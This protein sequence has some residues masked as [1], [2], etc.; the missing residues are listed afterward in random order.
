MPGSGRPGIWLETDEFFRLESGTGLYSH[1]WALIGRDQELRDL[2][3]WLAS[4]RRNV[5]LVDGRGGI[6]KSR[7]LRTFAIKAA[8]HSYAVRFLDRSFSA[9]LADIELLPGT[10]RLLVVVDD[11]HESP[12][13][14]TTVAS[15]LRARPATKILLAT[16]P[17]GVDQLLSDIRFAGLHPTEVPHWLLG[18][19]SMAEA[20]DLAAAVL[21]SG[22]DSDVSRRLAAIGHDCPLIIV[23]GAGLVRQGVLD[24][25]HMSNDNMLRDEVMRKFAEVLATDAAVAEPSVRREVLQAVAALQ[26]FRLLQPEFRHV[27]E[28]LTGK[29][30]DQ[31]LVHLRQLENSGVLLRRGDAMRIVPDLLGDAIL[32][33][34]SVDIPSGA[35]TGYLDRVLQVADGD[36]LLNLVHNATRIDWNIRRPGF[37]PRSSLVDSLWETLVTRF[38]AADPQEQLILLRRLRPMAFYRQAPLLKIS[39]LAYDSAQQ[40]DI[41]PDISDWILAALPPILVKAATALDQLADSVDLLWDLAARKRH[42]RQR[43]QD[44][45]VEVLKELAGFDRTK[46]VAFNLGMVD[47]VRRWIPQRRQPRPAVSPREILQAVLA[48]Q[49]EERVFDGINVTLSRHLLNRDVVTPVRRAAADLILEGLTAP[50]RWEA[51]RAAEVLAKALE[52]PHAYAGHSIPDEQID[53][54][55]SDFLETLGLLRQIIT[56]TTVDPVVA[57]TLRKSL[58]WHARHARGATNPAAR[59]VLEALPGAIEYDFAV[60]L[61]DGWGH[62]VHEES[63]FQEA[64]RVRSQW[65][66]AFARVVETTWS[67]NELLENLVRGLHAEQEAAPSG[68]NANPEPFA[69]ALMRNR[70]SLARALV[71][72]VIGEPASP[73]KSLLPVAVREL[74]LSAADVGWDAVDALLGSGDPE[75]TRLTAASLHRF[76]GSQTMIDAREC[77]TLSCLLLHDDEVI[78][79]QALLAVRQISQ[80]DKALATELLLTVSFEHSPKLAEDVLSAFGEHG[81]LAYEELGDTDRERIL[82]EISGLAAINEYA[83]HAF[84]AGLSATYPDEIL[85]LLKRRSAAE[86]RSRGLSYHALPERWHKNLRVRDSP[87]FVELLWDVLIWISENLEGTGGLDPGAVFGAVAVAYDDVVLDVLDRAL[88]AGTT[89]YVNAVAEVLGHAHHTFVW[90]HP[91][92][93]ARA[94]HAANENGEDCRRAVSRALHS[95][96]RQDGF[97]GP[98]G[99]PAPQH[100]EQRDR[101]R[102]IAATLTEGTLEREFFNE[103]ATAAESEIRD[104][105]ERD[106]TYLESRDW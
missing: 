19:L 6:G 21:G 62:L 24:P 77:A 75:L 31:V 27:A 12:N 97:G 96:V 15:L 91:D 63:D 79:R 55:T 58:S 102:S 35:P 1:G 101:S 52:Y 30:F 44:D 43:E 36:A 46:P 70:P 29:A 32:T 7:L 17:Y 13:V 81:Y 59:A 26:P 80:H 86:T 98:I 104:E 20:A 22:H 64:H 82:T 40:T 2:V 99:E 38:E 89:Q 3:A 66:D 87:R 42:N 60:A 65:L 85:E 61:H 92:F 48:T 94:L 76:R 84:L 72:V 34:A 51:T 103:L 9:E 16:R 67:E 69:H 45:P 106:R 95:S 4:E 71:R 11:A 54:W 57:V 47:A 25:G 83:I 50:D 78:R 37:G 18:D 100:L 10:D 73:L 23:V 39:K 14:S 56:T 53:G 33:D 90:D 8:E 105:S 68:G 49:I 93:V 41:D 88:G 28:A 74:L 5:A